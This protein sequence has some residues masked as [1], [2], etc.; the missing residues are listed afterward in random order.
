MHRFTLELDVYAVKC[1]VMI[2]KKPENVSPLPLKLAGLFL[3]WI[4]Q[5]QSVFC[6]SYF[7]VS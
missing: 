1:T 6:L 5:L 7:L 3:L 2:G 4:S